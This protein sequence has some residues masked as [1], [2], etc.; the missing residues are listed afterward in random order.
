MCV[1]RHIKCS[2][3]NY[4]VIPTTVKVAVPYVQCKLEGLYINH[5]SSEDDGSYYLKLFPIVH[6]VVKVRA[7]R[8]N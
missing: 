6:F 5:I 3:L 4:V 2:A 1:Y 7:C 8:L